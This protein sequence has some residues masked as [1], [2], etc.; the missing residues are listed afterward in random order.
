MF[1]MVCSVV[2][3]D[4]LKS[5]KRHTEAAQVLLD[6]AGDVVEGVVT[7][8]EGSCWEEALRLAHLHCQSNLV[9]SHIR[10]SVMEAASSQLALFETMETTFVRHTS[11]LEVVRR[12]KREKEQAILGVRLGFIGYLNLTIPTPVWQLQNINFNI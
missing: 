7:L 1:F 4:H 2:F 12:L 11:R 6:Y 8:L 5:V 3:L 10:P 9:E